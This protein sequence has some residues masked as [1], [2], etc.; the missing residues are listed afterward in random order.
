MTA[1]QAAARWRAATVVAVIAALL[2]ACGEDGPVEATPAELVAR[3]EQLDGRAVRTVGRVATTDDPRHYWIEDPQDHRIG[4]EPP[5]AVEE[6]VGT[7]VLVEGTFHYAD[8]R[9]RRIEAERVEPTGGDPVAVG[10]RFGGGM[11]G[12]SGEL[13]AARGR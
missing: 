4:V 12:P 5:E 13:R 6:H 1:V 2:V 7:E 9:G 11:P 10:R 8:D 3:Q